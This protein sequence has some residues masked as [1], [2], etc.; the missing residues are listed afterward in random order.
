M[1]A[2]AEPQRYVRP[3]AEREPREREIDFSPVGGIVPIAILAGIAYVGYTYKDKI[4]EILKNLDSDIQK[5]IGDFPE[6][7]LPSFGDDNDESIASS[8]SSSSS[9]SSSPAPVLTNAETDSNGI[10]IPY[11][12]TGKTVKL[13]VGSRHPNGDRY[14]ANHAFQNYYVVAYYKTASGQELLEMK[15]DG[16]NHSGCSALP[17]CE[18]AEPAFELKGGKSHISSE[19]PH[20]KNH[21]AVTGAGIQL[22]TVAGNWGGKSIGYGVAAYNGPGGNRVYDQWVDTGGLV[23]GKPANRWVRTIHAT[24]TGNIMPNPKRSLPTSGRGL[25]AEI[26]C[27]GGHGTSMSLGNIYEIV[28]PST[29]AFA[30][31]YPAVVDEMRPLYAPRISMS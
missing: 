12:R 15:T 8:G 23:G 5:K 19:Y 16:P 31:A 2:E 3:R 1:S 4:L 11:K 28:P 13:N 22:N 20:P 27:H 17:K 24:N 26:R 6:I 25:E 10:K 9:S 29:A 18:W 7:Q 21:P 14:N 30:R